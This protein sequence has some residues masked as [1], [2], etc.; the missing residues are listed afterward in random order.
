MSWLWLT[1]AAL[2]LP[3]LALLLAYLAAPAWLLRAV[4]D[5]L[6]RRGRLAVR[7]LHAGGHDWPYLEGGPRGGTPLV[8]VHGFGGDKDHWALI[9]RYLTRDHH[10]IIPDLVGFGDNGRDASLSYAI[11]DQSARL[12][13][14]LDA[15]GLGPCHIV[16]N[17]MGGWIALTI[18]LTT[19][20]RLASLTLVNNAGVIGTVE[21][22]LQQLAA[23]GVNP[24]KL[25]GADDVDRLLAFVNHRPRRVPARFKQV[26]WDQRAPDG[27]LLD[28]IFAQI[29]DEGLTA[30]LNDRLGEVALPT[31]IIWGQHD[32][33]INVSSSAVLA[34][35]IAGAEVHVFDDVGHVPM[36]EAPARTAG[37]LR[38]FLAKQ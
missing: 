31:L 30:P 36:I 12:G 3:L 17:S 37:V 23:A 15:L 22:E 9:A 32:R 7:Q 13:A 29:A 26:V 8:L 27:P 35:G 2:L 25:T 4:R 34:S 28:Q 11:A 33:L 1:L 38:A 19:P 5:W 24:L 14:F 20:P 18:A 21:S 16:G 6:R 10:V